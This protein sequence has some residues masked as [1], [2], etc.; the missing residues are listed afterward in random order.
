[1]EVG[2][3]DGRVGEP[4]G[5]RKLLEPCWPKAREILAVKRRR[6]V[7]MCVTKC[8]ATPPSRVRPSEHTLVPVLPAHPRLAQPYATPPSSLDPIARYS[9]LSRAVHGRRCPNTVVMGQSCGPGINDS[10]AHL[11]VT[12][13][14]TTAMCSRLTKRTSGPERA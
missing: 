11:T 3:L 9:G 8:T 6:S 4:V 5:V 13:H 1:M 7:V 12:L 14:L 2:A 10:A